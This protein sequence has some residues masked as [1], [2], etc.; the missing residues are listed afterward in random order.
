MRKRINGAVIVALVV[1]LSGAT[2]AQVVDGPDP[3]GIIVD[4]P[5]PVG[6]TFTAE[7]A[8]TAATGWGSCTSHDMD[9]CWSGCEDVRDAAGG[10]YTINRVECRVTSQGQ[11]ACTCVI[12]I[13]GPY[14]PPPACWPVFSW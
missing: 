2:A 12:N 5:T 9:S 11:A 6:T 3:V 1:M 8:P 4:D 13:P 7:L 10:G 14:Y